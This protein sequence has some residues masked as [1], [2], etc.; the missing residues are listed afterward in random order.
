LYPHIKSFI[1]NFN[2][3]E[4]RQEP[5]TD[6]GGVAPIEPDNGTDS[7]GN[8]GGMKTNNSSV[9]AVTEKE[10]TLIDGSDK[11]LATGN[12][13]DGSSNVSDKTTELPID[14]NAKD[15]VK[16]PDI[17]M[18]TVQDGDFNFEIG[19]YEITQA[20]W[21]AVMGSNPSFKFTGDDLPV[22]NVTFTQV[23]K[24][25]KNLNEKTGKNY[26]LPTAAE[27]KYAAKGGNKSKGY[28]YSGSNNIDEVAWYDGNSSVR[29]HA[30]GSLSPN[31][32]GIYD[33]SGNV[34]EW[35]QDHLTYGGNWFWTAEGCLVSA[36]AED[37]GTIY[38]DSEVGF[39]L[40]RTINK[41]TNIVQG[42]VYVN[43]EG[44]ENHVF[45]MV[46]KNIKQTMSENDCWSDNL[47]KA[48]YELTLTAVAGRIGEGS[49][50]PVFYRA[51]MDVTLYNRL[52]AEKLSFTTSKIKYAEGNIPSE[53]KAITALTNE[54]LNK[55]KPKINN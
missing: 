44:T 54:I 38:K 17:K 21:K 35:S 40:A 23:Q 20:Q 5:I 31:E 7:I 43:C 11:P 49:E 4:F 50:F 52:T 13:M 6:S 42:S 27:W 15:I 18:I 41:P 19:K 1:N 55:I 37:K 9:G 26:R 12:N 8:G 14:V 33:M 48:N 46:C 16:A 22:Q 30:V 25:I 45:N 29:T 10:P 39:R 36:P 47:A 32:L 2:Q 51:N 28:K 3:T 34:S 53:N 24:F